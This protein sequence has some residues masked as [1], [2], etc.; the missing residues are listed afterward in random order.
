MKK[1]VY[2]VSAVA[3][4]HVVIAASILCAGGCGTTMPV[5][6]GKPPQPTLPAPVFEPTPP[7]TKPIRPAP[8]ATTAKTWSADTTAY[9]VQNGD[10]L[11]L[12]AQRFG[13]SQAEILGLNQMKDAN[14]VM[15]G[16]TL[17]LPGKVDVNAPR[18][19]I[20]KAPAAPKAAKPASASAATSATAAGTYVV[21]PGDSLSR[22][23]S[24]NKVSLSALRQANDLKGDRIM[25][26]QKLKLPG[27]AETPVASAAVA[28][29]SAPSV[30]VPVE[31]PTTPTTPPPAVTTPAPTT[32]A[33]TTPAPTATAEPVSST[34]SFRSHTVELGEDLY[35]VS[36]MWDVSVEELQSLNNITGTA[37]T[38]GQVLKIPMSE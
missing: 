24:R 17:R 11:S 33:V 23:A 20:K 31:P 16:Q 22:I 7:P 4:M 36:L 34:P 26:G 38:P 18:P 12:I 1:S 37:L 27:A 10:S 2:V 14:K 35:H 6:T 32:P 19:V 13:V 15:V 30:S 3:G 9:T 5:A 21:Q 8:A 25:A 29:A 28:P